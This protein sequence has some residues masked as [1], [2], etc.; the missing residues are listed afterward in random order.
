M[1]P[2]REMN[3]HVGSLSTKNIQMETSE[4]IFPTAHA[5]LWKQPRMY[6]AYFIPNH[7]ILQQ[8]PTKMHSAEMKPGSPFPRHTPSLTIL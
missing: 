4:V 8:T 1:I 6:L 3:R 2:G 5:N 7:A